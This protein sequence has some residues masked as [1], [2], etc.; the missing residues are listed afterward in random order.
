M[1]LVKANSKNGLS[2]RPWVHHLPSGRNWSRLTQW[3]IKSFRNKIPKR[4]IW[5]D[6]NKNQRVRER[7]EDECGGGRRSQGSSWVWETR[8][9]RGRNEEKHWLKNEKK[10]SS[11]EQGSQEKYKHKKQRQNNWNLTD[12]GKCKFLRSPDWTVEQ[13]HLLLTPLIYPIGNVQSIRLDEQPSRTWMQDKLHPQVDL[14]D[15]AKDRKGVEKTFQAELQD[16]TNKDMNLPWDLNEFNHIRK[17]SFVFFFK[18]FTCSWW[19]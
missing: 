8:E 11:M 10:C 14:M 3:I 7:R 19:G 1:W 16:Q 12:Y 5:V 6:K 17:T 4:K 15:G 18:A 2:L 9:M 13:L